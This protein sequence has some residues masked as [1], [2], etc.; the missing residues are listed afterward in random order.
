MAILVYLKPQSP[1][2]DVYMKIRLYCEKLL[3]FIIGQLIL[4]TL[5]ITRPSECVKNHLR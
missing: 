1:R 3:Q 4:S 5:L 2:L